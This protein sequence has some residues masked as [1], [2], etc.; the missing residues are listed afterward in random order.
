MHEPEPE[1]Q[2]NPVAKLFYD[3]RLD[4]ILDEMLKLNG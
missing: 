4:V 2:A 1:K 3:E